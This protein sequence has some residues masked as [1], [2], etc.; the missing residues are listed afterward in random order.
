[1]IA[2]HH[3]PIWQR[4]RPYLQTRSNERH[5]SYCYVFAQQLLALHPDAD[6]E[7][8]LPALLLHD[9]GW[10]TVPEEKQLLAF[11]P[12]MRYPE[13]RRQH[14]TEGVRIAGEILAGLGW[15]TEQIVPITAIIDGHDTRK[16]SLSLND[17][18]VKDADKLW[19]YTP[20]G[21]ETVGGW[22]GYTT[23]EQLNLL[24]KWLG[25]RFYTETA[26][27]MARGLLANLILRIAE[28]K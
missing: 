25:Y 12:N 22:F 13:L 1:M 15:T 2:S 20:F 3:Q 4:A 14:E 18:L 17:A 6:A 19:R 10:S 5:T 7:I 21:L 28:S 16:E 11:G 9:V 23:A 26:V 24:E 27:H 8:V